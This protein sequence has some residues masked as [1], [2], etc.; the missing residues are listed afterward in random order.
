MRVPGP[1]PGA[2]AP[3]AWTERRW[4]EL[5]GWSQAA[6]T[7]TMPVVLDAP[8][9]DPYPA[10]PGRR[11]VV[12]ESGSVTSSAS[13]DPAPGSGMPDMPASRPGTGRRR[14]AGLAGAGLAVLVAAGAGYAMTGD[15]AG[16]PAS[17]VPA[18]VTSA[19]TS[20]PDAHPVKDVV[21]ATAAVTPASAAPSASRKP[22]RRRTASA[23]PSATGRIG[24]PTLTVGHGTQPT[25]GTP[26]VEPTA[27]TGRPEPDST[28]TEPAAATG[29][30]ATEPTTGCAVGE[31]V[32]S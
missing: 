1:G 28:P 32:C 26:T 7:V 12:A 9:D 8:D 19:V 22:K 17:T 25:S 13:S 31:T 5:D 10:S 11:L 16:P 2:P 29:W 30:P 27:G 18:P 20:V 4:A 3:D 14:W 24:K 15:G 6:E 21:P 23:S